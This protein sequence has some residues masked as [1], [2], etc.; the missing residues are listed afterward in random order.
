VGGS[1]VFLI[2]AESEDKKN[3]SMYSVAVHVDSNANLKTLA[4]STGGLTPAFAPT[5]FAYKS[6]PAF[7]T[8]ELTVTPTEDEEGQVI[9]VRFS[10]PARGKNAISSSTFIHLGC[11]SFA[12]KVRL[13]I[14]SNGVCAPCRGGDYAMTVGG[15]QGSEVRCG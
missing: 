11:L 1:Q 10:T 2:T 15:W 13:W 14:L 9:E 5:T 4:I 3:I 12:A 7:N 6:A 8:A